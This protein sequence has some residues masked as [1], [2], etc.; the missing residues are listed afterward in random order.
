MNLETAR[1]KLKLAR[2]KASKVR[3]EINELRQ[4]IR[5]AGADPDERAVTT[6]RNKEMYKAWKGGKSFA[7]IATEFKRSQTT[8]RNTCNLIEIILERRPPAFEKYK[9]LVGYKNKG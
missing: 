6:E 8:V 3:K 5:D 9:D 1:K 4:I 7:Q 2:A